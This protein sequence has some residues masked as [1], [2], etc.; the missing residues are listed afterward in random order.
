MQFLTHEIGSLAKPPWLV[1]T[2]AGRPLDE[3]D[4]QHAARWGEKVGVESVDRR[5][6]HVLGDRLR[7]HVRSVRQSERRR[8]RHEPGP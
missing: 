2:S 4:L 8:Q 3:S 1:K 5:P 6:E 7:R